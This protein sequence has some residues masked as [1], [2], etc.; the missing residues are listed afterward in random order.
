[1]F[2]QS[3]HSSD[4]DSISISAEQGSDFAKSVSNDFNPIHDTDGKRFCVPGDLLFALVLQRYGLSQVMSF[5]FSGMV[6]A[7]TALFFPPSVGED[8][9]IIDDRDK[10]YLG[11]SRSGDNAANMCLVEQLVKVYVLFSGQNFPHIL[12]PLMAEHQVM[13][14]PVRPLVIYDSMSLRL[15]R[16][17]LTKPTVELAGTSLRVDG[18]RGEVQLQFRFMDEGRIVGSG[19]KKL[20][21][22]GL[23]EYQ[24]DAIDSMVAD[25]LARAS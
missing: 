18:K 9:R 4:Q 16:L 14:N 6:S 11:V 13:I 20:I 12:V 17:T 5:N 1:M 8:F 21:L 22:S 23:R 25:Y 19:V 3:F 10:C 15:D 2:L 24:Q 7:D